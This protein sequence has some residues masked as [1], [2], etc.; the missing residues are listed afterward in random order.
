MASARQAEPW[1]GLKVWPPDWSSSSARLAVGPEADAQAGQER[2]AQGRR[3]GLR[4][5]ADRLA[6][7]VGLELEERVGAGHAAVDPEVGEGRSEVF[8]DR[9]DQVGDLEGDALERGAG[10]VGQAGG[11]GQAEDRARGPR[12]ASAGAPRPVRA[13]TKVTSLAGSASRARSP[14][15]GAAPMALSPSRNHWTAAPAMKTLPSSANCGRSV[16]QRGGPG[17]D[18][19]LRG[20][21]G[22]AAGVGQQEGARAVGALGLAGLDAALADQRRLLV[23]GDA[24]DRDAVGQ[25]VEARGHAEIARRWGGSPAIFRAGT[26]KTSQSSSAQLPGFQVH[27]QGPRG[28]GDVGEMLAAAGQ[29]PDQQRIDGPRGQL[30][31]HARG[32]AP[33][34]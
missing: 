26:S 24:R 17:R 4:A 8:L 10:D 34:T 12:A 32:R 29:V 18:Q 30:A 20:G 15:S 19:P 1:A 16:A 21:D 25:V 2:G 5:A 27:E 11:P 3:F 9:L 13:G 22:V 7:H 23:A 28:V 14:I 31:P 33:G 6:Q